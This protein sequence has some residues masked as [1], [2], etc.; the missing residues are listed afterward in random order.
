VAA[1]DVPRLPFGLFEF[2]SMPFGLRNA[3]MTF[4]QLRDFILG[5]LPFAFV[6]L[7]DI[8]LVSPVRALI[9]DTWMQL[10]TYAA[11]VLIIN[12]DKCPFGCPVDF[13]EHRLTAGGISTLSSRVQPSPIFPSR[14]PSSSF[15]HFWGSSTSTGGLFRRRH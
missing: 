6:Y 8:L 15:R 14:P 13:L 7:N 12:P 4:Q 10:S 11:N 5:D 9:S 2:T 1:K 3:G